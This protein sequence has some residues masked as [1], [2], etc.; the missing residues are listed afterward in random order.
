M[1]R[2]LAVEPGLSAGA[3]TAKVLTLAAGGAEIWG[4]FRAAV[5]CELR[6]DGRLREIQGWGGKLP[7]SV[8]RIAGL[9]H[10]AS[11]PAEQGVIDAGTMDRAVQIAW[12]LVEH[13]TAVFQL[14]GGD[15]ATDD[16]KL[17]YEWIVR[18]GRATFTRTGV[19]RPHHSRFTAKKR[20]DAALQVLVDRRIVNRCAR[21][22]TR[23]PGR[24]PE[25][26]EVNP[27]IFDRK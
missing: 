13:A 5:E 12:L 22:E 15:P 10:L 24:P 16:A 17:L 19:L 3:E 7:G 21:E 8:L 9:L 20:L 25:V 27:L 14:M 1:S 18:E 6:P 26:Y 2:L 11:N 4:K 23:R